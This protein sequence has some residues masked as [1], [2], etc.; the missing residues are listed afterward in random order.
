MVSPS[1]QTIDLSNPYTSG[2][3][4]ADLACYDNYSDW[5]VPD[6]LYQA[7]SVGSGPFVM[8]GNLPT[9]GKKSQMIFR[10]GKGMRMFSK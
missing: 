1:P 3:S 4:D 10:F 2:C 5:W 8:S 9:G 7:R 6:V